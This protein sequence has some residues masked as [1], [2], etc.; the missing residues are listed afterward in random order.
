MKNRSRC[1]LATFLALVLCLSTLSLSAL[2][3]SDTSTD[4]WD[5][6]PVFETTDVHGYLVDT[7]TG[8]EGTFQYRLAYIS[9]VVEAARKDESNKAVLLL[10]GGDIYQ[11]TPVSNMTYGNAIRAA[12]DKMEYDAV[13]LGNHEFDWDV[14]TYAAESDGTMPAYTVTT[15]EGDSSPITGNSTIPVLASNLYYAAGNT[16]G[17]PGQRVDFTKDYV[18]LDKGG[19]KVAVV[20]Y[21]PD[22]AKSI[23]SAKIAPYEI[24]ADLGALNALCAKVKSDEQADVVIVLAH[25]SPA[26]IADAMDPAVVNLVCGGH[27]HVGISGTSEKTGIS[28]IQGNCQGQGY[29][30]AEIRINPN[31]KEVAV[32]MPSYIA[33]PE[34]AKFYNNEANAAN[35]DQEIVAIGNKSWASVGDTMGEVLGNVDADIDRDVIPGS[36]LNSVAGN[37]LSDLMNRATGSVIAAVNSGGI[38][39][40]FFL[41]DAATRNITAGEIY[42][43]SPFGNKV[44]A[45]NLTGQEIADLMLFA[46]SPAGSHLDLRFSGCDV[47][48]YTRG[49]TNAI[50][51]IKLTQDGTVIYPVAAGNEGKTYLVSTNEYA[52]TYAG[53]PFVGKVNTNAGS[54]PL[55]ND[56][57]IAAL[58]EEGK[59]NGGKLAVD[60]A[61]HIKNVAVPTESLTVELSGALS[62]AEQQKLVIEN[63]AKSL[64]FK[65]STLTVVIPA[66]T[67]S[68]GADISKMLV[69]PAKSSGNAIRVTHT[70]ATTSV[71]PF[72]VIADKT[73]AYIADCEGTYELIDNAKVFPDV[74]EGNWAYDAVSFAASR[75]LFGGLSNGNFGA[76]IPMT[77][78]MLVAVLARIDSGTSTAQTEFTDVPSGLWY[79]NAVAWAAE[80]H[81]AEGA[82]N[83]FQPEAPIT[84]EQLC[85]ILARYMNY[86]GIAL[87]DSPNAVTPTDFNSVSPWAAD[88]VNAALK[89][90]LISGKSGD[91]LDPQ[92]VA[93]RGEIAV[94]LMNFISL[95]TH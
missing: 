40:D 22:Y 30:T 73:A 11:G 82:G 59:V 67:L 50:R 55:D 83:R 35:L 28:Y 1:F 13:S 18:V 62:A 5:R 43:I 75:E 7:S 71:L 89:S 42:T 41:N 44:M 20:G 48:Y 79:S 66:G 84:R 88:A 49:A 37:W 51:E 87:K 4:S 46:L 33:K 23:M 19:Y 54:E 31:T 78:A 16:K 65:S 26:N 61:G 80:N 76:E 45:Y 85:T 92:G 39:T 21:I 3:V 91:Q 68:T 74:A 9:N 36:S 29:G 57:A 24:R 72:C 47:Q 27:S 70:D 15:G 63:A 6:I 69:D 14:T 17:T 58:R 34:K 81:I 2:A 52:A 94:V 8:T 95:A 12:Y 53:T 60:T 38:R 90:G 64:V 25:D 56:S 32:L 77:R 86:A 10:D 93:T